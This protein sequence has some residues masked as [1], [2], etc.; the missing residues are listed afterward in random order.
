MEHLKGIPK[1]KD[2]FPLTNGI[3]TRMDYDFGMNNADIDIL[4]YTDFGRK[5][6]APLPQHLLGTDTYLSSEA[7]NTL[8]RMILAKFKN[9]WDR[10]AAILEQEY[11]PIH[12]YLDE[13]SE[14]VDG[15]RDVTDT[16]TKNLLTGDTEA[17]SYSNTRTDNLT[18]HVTSTDDSTTT[19]TGADN[20]YG[21]NSSDPTGVTTDSESTTVDDDGTRNKTNTGTQQNNSTENK[22]RTISN[23]GTDTDVIDEDTTKDREGYHKG[24]IG[25]IST[26]KLIKEELELWKWNFIEEA[27]NDVRDFLTLPM[28]GDYLIS[29]EG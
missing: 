29:Q 11:D 7:L 24:N 23:T 26:Q 27:L 10:S 17:N 12:N 20:R 16:R 8:A 19:V 3:F 14:N 9:K 4:F 18:E 28:Y 6:I 13:F 21:L 1:V 2:V 5:T 15:T 22:T 25:N